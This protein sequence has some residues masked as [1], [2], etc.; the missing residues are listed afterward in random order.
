MKTNGGRSN[1]DQLP[2]FLLV[3]NEVS[4]R[5]NRN[6]QRGAL[7]DSESALEEEYLTP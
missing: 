2:L 7:L 6:Y 5:R 3:G 4:G 1:P